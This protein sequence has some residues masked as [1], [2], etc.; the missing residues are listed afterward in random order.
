MSKTYL[1]SLVG[2]S[3]AFKYGD[4]P[5]PSWSHF[6]ID[7]TFRAPWF[8]R[9][10]SEVYCLLC[11]AFANEGHLMSKKH[12]ERAQA[13]EWYNFDNSA[14]DWQ[15]P[16]LEPRDDGATYCHLCSS[17]ADQSHMNSAKHKQREKRPEDYGFSRSDA[18]VP[19]PQA[20]RS[21]G[22]AEAPG[23]WQTHLCKDSGKF[24]YHNPETGVAQWEFPSQQKAP[25]S[26]GTISD[27]YSEELCLA[28][29]SE[30]S[31]P[32]SRAN[33]EALLP[34]ERVPAPP[35]PW[36]VCFCVD[37][38]KPYYHNPGTGSTQWEFPSLPEAPPSPWA[39]VAQSSVEHSDELCDPVFNKPWFEL[40][41]CEWYC[42]LCDKFATMDHILS[43]MHQKREADPQWYLTN[44]FGPAKA[45][46]MLRVVPRD[47]EA[48]H[49]SGQLPATSGDLGARR[50]PE[51]TFP[52]EE[53]RSEDGKPYYHNQLTKKSQWERPAEFPPVPGQSA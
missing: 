4:F 7:Q 10:D 9:R 37:N 25:L 47:R 53:H 27:S 2:Q 31:G 36:Q 3:A 19:Q 39:T 34:V 41:D 23:P 18:R 6:G 22:P 11:N 45:S 51:A 52:W 20:E 33:P 46:S 12:R 26:P 38:E 16:W 35:A 24:Y 1:R 30:E 42:L 17:W 43:R 21:R 44:S 32:F 29:R 28:L 14:S 8:E 5:R 48:A 40:Q 50:G 15:R 49:G 13:P